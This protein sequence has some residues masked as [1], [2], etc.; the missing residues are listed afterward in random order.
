[1]MH[2]SKDIIFKSSD[3]HI[4]TPRIF[5]I[6]MMPTN[7]RQCTKTVVFKKLYIHLNVIE[8][9][10]VY[11]DQ[12]QK[13]TLNSFELF[14]SLVYEKIAAKKSLRLSD[15]VGLYTTKESELAKIQTQGKRRAGIFSQIVRVSPQLQQS[16]TRC[17]MAEVILSLSFALL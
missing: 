13:Q 3:Q 16:V 11:L 6:V 12:Q 10:K 8:S 17:V 2:L 9:G 14:I 4:S 15:H 5:R 7:T 1:M